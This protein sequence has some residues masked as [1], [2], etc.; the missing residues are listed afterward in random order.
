M[1]RRLNSQNTYSKSLE[2]NFRDRSFWLEN[3]PEIP[4]VEHYVDLLDVMLLS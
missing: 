3:L 2:G 1:D 4:E